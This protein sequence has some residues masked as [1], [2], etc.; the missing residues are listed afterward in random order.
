VLS[1]SGSHRLPKWSDS[2]YLLRAAFEDLLR[3]EILHQKKLGFTL[4]I[5]QWM[6]GELRPLCESS[7]STLKTSGIVRPEGVDAVW[8]SFLAA[9][10][11]QAWSRA[12]ALVVL[13][14][15]IQRNVG[16]CV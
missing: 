3:P 8:S 6:A 16:V 5:G 10:K 15:F 13:G 7:L 9:P 12:L 4:P 1:I 2:K 11:S 14:E